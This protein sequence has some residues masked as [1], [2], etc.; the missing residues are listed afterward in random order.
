[1]TEERG[2]IVAI[3]T[4]TGGALALIRMSGTEAIAIGDRI[5]RGNSDVPLR[6]AK[7]YTLHFG[8]I[9]NE[10]DEIIDEVL[11]SLFRAPHSY[12][13]EDMIEISC[14]GSPFVQQEILRR[15]IQAGARIA[16]GGEFTLRAFL[17]GK[18]DLSQAEAV[19]DIIASES[20]VALTLASR[21]IRGG[22]SEEF[23][24][25]RQR[26]LELTS[27]LELE[28]DF[29]EEDVEF[30]DRAHLSMMLAEVEQ[31]IGSLSD[32][33]RL[34]NIL[35]NGVPVAIVGSPNVGKSTLLNALLNEDRALVSDIAGTTRDLIE[36][37]INI[38]GVTFRFIDTAG[39]RAT[40]DPLEHL[41]IERTLGRV[42]QSTIILLLVNADD[43]MEE[44]D[45]QLNSIPL[46]TGQQIAL[47]LNKI[48]R[49][50][51]A[52]ATLWAETLRQKKALPVLAVSAKLRENLQTL[53]SW[54]YDS[55]HADESLHSGQ[56]VISNARHHE[57]LEAAR[58]ATHRAQQSLAEGL[59]NDLLAQ[60]IREVL[61]HLGTI[62]GEITSQEVL[63]SIFSK[64][65]IGK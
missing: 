60:D 26:L 17:A 49:T 50:D 46:E 37:T 48:D 57:A 24:S 4:G 2:T 63:N 8:Q 61:H 51:R 1:M 20:Q 13:G 16:Q 47:I 62:T 28:L 27:L 59:P 53:T 35:K 32:S 58:Q 55:I 10:A 33:F 65:C 6:E 41:G 54:L 18:M 56:P 30:A 11:I 39:I 64:F 40:A 43:S 31:R 38:R 23:A 45:M 12:T 14:H 52:K 21:Q 5:F 34:G 44:I 15:C 36:E 29:S 9:Y 25:L 22:Y 19:A 42:R 3:A 7:G